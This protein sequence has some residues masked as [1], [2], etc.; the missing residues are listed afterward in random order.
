LPFVLYAWLSGEFNI[1]TLA[2]LF[3]A[4]LSVGGILL[5]SLFSTDKHEA[6]VDALFALVRM[7]AEPNS[8]D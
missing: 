2:S 6:E 7:A 5:F 8:D 4:A 3:F 1:G